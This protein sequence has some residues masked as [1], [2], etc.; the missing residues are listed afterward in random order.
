MDSTTEWIVL[1]LKALKYACPFLP[2]PAQ[3]NPV[4]SWI[5]GSVTLEMNWVPPQ[6]C[7]KDDFS[8]IW[9]CTA[10]AAEGGVTW[11]PII[12]QCCHHCQGPSL[13]LR[14][15]GVLA[16]PWIGHVV[17][18]PGWWKSE[19]FL[20]WSHI[21]WAGGGPWELA[22]SQSSLD[23]CCSPVLLCLWV[24]DSVKTLWLILTDRRPAPVLYTVRNEMLNS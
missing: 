10:Q 16:P 15:D 14:T 21:S 13:A 8:Y 22:E 7:D 23:G 19:W 2:L 17:S 18:I 1:T 9:C 3:K 12:V 5:T 4:S 6:G 11:F 20:Y 24:S